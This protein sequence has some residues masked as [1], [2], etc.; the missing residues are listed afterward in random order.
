MQYL[1][2]FIFREKTINSTFFSHL[3]VQLTEKFMTLLKEMFKGFVLSSYLN[4]EFISLSHV[5]MSSLEQF[6]MIWWE[7]QL[8][9][10]RISSWPG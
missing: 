9:H 3:T 7:I 4:H 10:S 5:L 8:A 1:R 6:V 2:I